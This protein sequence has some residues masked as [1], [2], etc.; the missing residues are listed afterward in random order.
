MSNTMTPSAVA[1]TVGL[2]PLPS[3]QDATGRTLGEAEIAAVTQALRTGTLTATKGVFTKNF[4]DRFAK[5]LGIQHCH[6]SNSGTM[7]LHAMFAA[8][9]LEPGDEII[10]TPITDMGALTP[11]LYQGIIPVFADVDPLTC[12]VTAATIAARISPKTRAVIVTHLFGNC[13][14]M[15]PILE[16][17]KA[18]GL[19]LLE[20]CSQS[21]GA[22][23]HGQQVGTFGAMAAFSL[24]QGKHITTG[25][26][27][28]TVS[29]DAR[30]AR[31]VYLFLNKAWGYGDPKPDH[32]TMALNGRMSELCGAVALA[33]M[34]QLD[35][36]IQRR[37][38]LADELKEATAE[39]PGLRPVAPPQQSQGTYWK[40]CFMIDSEQ[41]V[42]GAVALGAKL[43]EVG[44]LSAPR[45]IQKPAFQC[46]VFV[47]KR[48]LGTSGWPLSIARPEAIDYDM[49]RYPGVRAG[50]NNILVLP[51][52]ERYE[53]RHV[54]YIATQLRRAVAAL[55]A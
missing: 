15:A 48:T 17:V 24:Q 11:M 46:Q 45:Y 38:W 26:G 7:S 55:R 9:H 39:L 49:S 20:D 1:S 30:L 28:L 13:C 27:G 14:E 25:E 54:E 32:Y 51:W 53:S 8:L 42:G 47:E 36:V 31:E 44:I 50:L 52:T 6:A 43:K 2:L 21:F 22:S 18:Q 16:L 12:N 40:F 41:I 34:D 29:N 33:Q 3:D 23:Y 5:W 4:Q 19:I 37:I 35:A 10:T